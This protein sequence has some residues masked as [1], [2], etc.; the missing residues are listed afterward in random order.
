MPWCGMYC[1][2][3]WVLWN[4]MNRETVLFSTVRI[5]VVDMYVDMYVSWISTICTVLNDADLLMTNNDK[6]WVCVHQKHLLAT[7]WCWRVKTDIM[8]CKR[9][10][11]VRIDVSWY[12]PVHFLRCWSGTVPAVVTTFHESHHEYKRYRISTYINSHPVI[13]KLCKE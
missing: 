11:F 6:L 13:Q 3:K 8:Y 5:Q 10:L 1:D 2:T 4:Y 9:A 7:G 12:L